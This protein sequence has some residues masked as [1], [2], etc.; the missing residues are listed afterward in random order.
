MV[1]S[2][3]CANISPGCLKTARGS[4]RR[5]CS[6]FK[7]DRSRR[8]KMKAQRLVCALALVLMFASAIPARAEEQAENPLNQLAWMMGGKWEANG[9][10]GPNGKP[11]HVEWSCHWGANHRTLEFT[12]W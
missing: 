3:S 7:I 9:E 4:V 8:M 10:K 5:W 12:T 6:E 11:F 2:R 1:L